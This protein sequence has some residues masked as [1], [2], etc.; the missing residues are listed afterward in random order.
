MKPSAHAITD[1]LRHNLEAQGLVGEKVIKG[2]IFFI[3]EIMK[4]EHYDIQI[5]TPTEGNQG[6]ILIHVFDASGKE[7]FIKPKTDL[8]N[9]FIS[10]INIPT[11]TIK[12]ATNG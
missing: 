9:K 6:S 2:I 3:K 7:V 4:I 10:F 1:Y 5:F 11:Y 12:F 8:M